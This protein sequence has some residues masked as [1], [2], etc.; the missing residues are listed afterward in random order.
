MNPSSS[1]PTGS[2]TKPAAFAVAA[3]AAFVADA[4]SA[5]WKKMLMLMLMPLQR[6]WHHPWTKMMPVCLDLTIEPLFSEREFFVFSLDKEDSELFLAFFLG[7]CIGKTGCYCVGWTSRC[8][9]G[10]TTIGW[11]DCCITGWTDCCVIT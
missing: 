3:A 5:S 1:S 4:A 2:A 11:T 9:I 7:C 6:Y 10:W 8:S